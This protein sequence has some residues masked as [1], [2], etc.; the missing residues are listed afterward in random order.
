[1]STSTPESIRGSLYMSAFGDAWGK[2]QEFE[3]N[4]V[5]LAEKYRAPFYGDFPQPASITDDTQMSLAVYNALREHSDFFENYIP[6][7][8][9]S[10]LGA[11]RI[12]GESFIQWLD[13]PRNVHWRAPGRTCLD[14]LKDLK[15]AVHESGELGINGF[16][17]TRWESKGCGANMRAPWVGYMTDW[18]REK[19]ASVARDQAIITHGHQEGTLAASLTAM[20]V[21]GILKG[22]IAPGNILETIHYEGWMDSLPEKDAVASMHHRLRKAL[23]E[24]D[25]F[26]VKHPDMDLCPIFGYGNT[27]DEAFVL[28]AVIADSFLESNL[29]AAC[30]VRALK[31]AA[32]ISGDSDSVA[33]I[34]GAFVGAFVGST[35]LV[36]TMEWEKFLEADY[37]VELS[38]ATDYFI[39]RI[40]A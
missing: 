8:K 36:E 13:D 29:T 6:G 2:G 1:M 35:E 23:D 11:R 31:R 32:F 33:F 28:A 21:H 14:A 22:E 3:K 7:D 24:Q 37:R 9:E 40:G 30:A 12:F 18:S 39:N 20:V 5:R 15:E 38:E 27:A 34:V 19:V 26:L 10:S 4:Y 17:G 25:P 16:E